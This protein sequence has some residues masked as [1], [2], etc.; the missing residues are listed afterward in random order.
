M[1]TFSTVSEWAFLAVFAIDQIILS[2][3]FVVDKNPYKIMNI[4]H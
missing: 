4:S 3:F 1:S 2:K